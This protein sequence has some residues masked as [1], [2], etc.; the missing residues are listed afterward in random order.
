MD[1]FCGAGGL[2]RG[3][4][5]AGIKV[6]AGIDNDARLKQTYEHNNKPSR[7][8]DQDI[9]DVNKAQAR[10][11]D[12]KELLLQ[13]GKLVLEAPP[14]FVVVENVPGL[15]NAYGQSA[16]SSPR[17]TLPPSCCRRTTSRMPSTTR[18]RVGGR[19]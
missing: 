1:F 10:Q 14:D 6:K 8:V 19:R 18:H 9:H 17:S 16:R 12:R 2:T 13:F 5:D 4:L 11:D 3:L 7:F 15:N